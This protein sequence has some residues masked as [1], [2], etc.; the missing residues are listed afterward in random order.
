MHPQ[1]APLTRPAPLARKDQVARVVVLVALCSTPALVCLHQSFV[2]D[3][4]IWW[5]LRSAEWILAHHAVPRTDPF[6]SFG[7]GKPWAAY[8]WLFQLIV[9]KLYQRWDLVGILAY[10]A[11]MLAA[12]TGAVYSLIRRFQPDFTKAVLLTMA[13]MVCMSRLYTPR[14]WL[15][16]IL[17]FALQMNLLMRARATGRAR[18]LLWLPLV[19]AAW[20]NTHIQF[21]NGLLVL[22]IA[23]LES[24][25]ARWWPAPQ[26]RIAPLKLW[27]ILAACFL[28]TFANPYGWGIYKVAYQLASQPGVLN[29][30]QELQA[31]PFRGIGDF[32][33]LFLA[34]AAAAALAWKR[35][36][37]FFE[38]ALLALTA[39]LSFRSQR[40]TWMLA[41]SAGVIFAAHIPSRPD[42]AYRDEA[43]PTRSLPFAP[44]F[45]TLGIALTVVAGAFLMRLNNPQ[46]HTLLEKDM[47]VRA[48]EIARQRG[49]SGPLYNTYDWGGFL[50]WNLRQ[51]V[52][53][54]GRANLYGDQRIDRSD[55]TWSGNPDWASDPDLSAAGLVI[56]PRKAALTQLLR[57]DHN[58][59]AV[60]ED[61]VAVVF[62]SRSA[63]ASQS[64][65]KAAANP[66]SGPGVL[67]QSSAPTAPPVPP[68][69]TKP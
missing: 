5:H 55:N 37:S 8:S 67:A 48:V 30:L 68:G 26:P 25:I 36:F 6:S 2:S 58:F 1:Q 35:R 53:I 10:T 9:Y 41:I 44:L 12:I 57:T 4:D 54:D 15:F 50:I 60:Y 21:I 19:F 33:L 23:A 16:T 51:P 28:A 66:I 62:V 40:D 64:A 49:Y 20:S 61:T 56:A 7:A 46:L 3:P 42:R 29:K 11:A 47:P 17:F 32:L 63:Q 34:F 52:S 31:V 38:V 22:G 59:D 65:A 43:E 13:V 69:T 27:S 24:S 39:F 14:P 45:A 18:L